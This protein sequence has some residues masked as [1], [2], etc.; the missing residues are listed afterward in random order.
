MSRPFPS[1][2]LRLVLFVVIALPAAV[3]HAQTAAASTKDSDPYPLSIGARAFMM[4]PA[5]FVGGFGVGLDASYSVVPNFAFGANAA[6]FFVDQGA[7]PDYCSRCVTS[8]NS[9]LLF[10]EGRL[11]PSGYVTPYA[12]LGLGHAHLAGQK[13][14]PTHYEEDRVTLG[15]EL[16][17][18][19]HYKALSIR[20]LAFHWQPLGSALDNDALLGF[21]VQLGVRL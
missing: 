3:A 1:C 6:T 13:V 9:E 16:G 18:E 4:P 10:A 21:G 20:A 5:G 7:D 12:R 14:S 15:A 11:W 19:L 17:A 8:G 2:L